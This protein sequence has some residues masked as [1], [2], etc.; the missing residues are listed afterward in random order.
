MIGISNKLRPT[1]AVVALLSSVAISFAQEYPTQTDAKGATR[2]TSAT[3]WERHWQVWTLI[4]D[5][6]EL[7]EFQDHRLSEALLRAMHAHNICSAGRETEALSIYAD[8]AHG[9]SPVRLAR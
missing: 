9:L 3:C 2:S 7:P 8:I 4:E 1:L 5:L 6:G